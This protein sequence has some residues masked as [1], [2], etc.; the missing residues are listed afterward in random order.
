MGTHMSTYEYYIY[1]Y[2]WVHMSTYE[3]LWVLMSTYEYIYEYIW[4][5]MSTNE[6]PYEY[7]MG[8]HMGTH[9]LGKQ[10]Q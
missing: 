4:V 7:Y 10:K 2:I 8:T 1:E 9:D 6:Y 3:Y 5:L